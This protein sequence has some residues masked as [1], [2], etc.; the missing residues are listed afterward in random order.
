MAG[1]DV[2]PALQANSDPL[3]CSLATTEV[4]WGACVHS[5]YA[6]YGSKSAQLVWREMNNMARLEGRG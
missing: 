6:Y 5:I 1:Y 3:H 2:D 4:R